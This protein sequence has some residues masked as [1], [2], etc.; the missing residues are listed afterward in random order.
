VGG[1][2]KSPYDPP[3][4]SVPITPVK[5]VSAIRKTWRWYDRIVSLTVY[6]TALAIGFYLMVNVYLPADAVVK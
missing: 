3:P 5:K 6:F 4:A 1:L 2:Y